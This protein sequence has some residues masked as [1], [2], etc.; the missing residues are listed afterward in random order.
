MI[1]VNK[2]A[3][4]LSDWLLTDEPETNMTSFKV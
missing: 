2:S 4:L 3:N 1:E